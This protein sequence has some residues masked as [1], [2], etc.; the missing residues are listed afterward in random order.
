MN[1]TLHVTIDK[2]TKD[3]A[4]KLAKELGF[5]LS[6]F[7]KAN[8]RFF[9]QTESFYVDRSP[10]MTPRLAATIKQAKK[11]FKQGKSIGPFT[12]SELDDFLLNQ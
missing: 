2:E 1:T 10:R 6:S 12:G 8:L 7:I 11:E 9:I 3:K 4:S 5:D